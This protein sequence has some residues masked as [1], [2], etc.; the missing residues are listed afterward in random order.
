[1]LLSEAP[2]DYYEASQSE[3]WVSSMNREIQS[4]KDM[5]VYEI[6]PREESRGKLIQSLWVYA[7]K[8]DPTAAEKERSF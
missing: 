8:T 5:K 7:V 1:M 4:F 3:D 6:C 2:K